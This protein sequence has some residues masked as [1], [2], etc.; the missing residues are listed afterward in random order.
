MDSF[1]LEILSP[2]RP[3]YKGDCVSLVVP[4]SDGMMGVM[5]HHEPLTAA[6]LDGELQFT[7]PDGTRK[8]C[9]VSR[10]MLDISQNDAR[11]LCDSALAP[12]EVDEALERHARTDALIAEQE[13]EGLRDYRRTQLAFANAVNTL[14]NRRKDSEK[15]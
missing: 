1:H 3:F 12:D 13:K 2:E 4:V 5:A 11:V 8:V 7:T 9:V 14:K 6:I 15:M 10:G